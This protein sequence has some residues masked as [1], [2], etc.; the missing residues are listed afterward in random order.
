MGMFP[1]FKWHSR[2]VHEERDSEQVKKAYPRT[3]GSPYDSLTVWRKS[4]VISCKGFMVI[5]SDG[6]LVY[7]FEW[8]K[9]T[10]IN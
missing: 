4:L 8:A 1:K 2:A 9:Q 3:E 5:N 6:N 7:R 10:D